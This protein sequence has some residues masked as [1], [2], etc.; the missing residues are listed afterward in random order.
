[1]LVCCILLCL[2][3]SCIVV[4]FLEGLG[5][6]DPNKKSDFGELTRLKTK[7]EDRTLGMEEHVPWFYQCQLAFGS[8]MPV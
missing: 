5:L 4:L 1:M 3:M 6:Q 2:G 8:S 7:T